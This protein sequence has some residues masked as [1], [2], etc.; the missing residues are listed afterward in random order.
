[1]KVDGH[2]FCQHIT[3]R[4]T[5]DPEQ[6]YVCHCNDCQTHSGTAFG[7]V[8][9]IVDGDFELRSGTL[10]TFNKTAASGT[11]R[12]LAFCPECGTRIHAKTVGEGSDFFG[13]RTGTITQRDQLKPTLQSW[14][15]SAQDWVQNINAIPKV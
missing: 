15:Q 9:G 7:V 10:K 2:C 6:V 1:M 8:V 3:Y 12:A 13:L 4:A 5:V 11:V 14:T